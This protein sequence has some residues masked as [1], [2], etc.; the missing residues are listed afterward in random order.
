MTSLGHEQALDLICHTGVVLS[1]Q[2]A[3][4][5]YL[6]LRDLGHLIPASVDR[7]G[8]AGETAKTGSTEGESAVPAEEQGDAQTPPG[9]TS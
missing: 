5:G 8:E 2:E 4:E 6:R 7:S 9:T 3:I 1:Y